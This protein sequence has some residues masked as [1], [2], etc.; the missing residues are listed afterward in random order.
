[1]N[2]RPEITSTIGV[3]TGKWYY[4]IY[5]GTVGAGGDSHFLGI[6]NRSANSNGTTIT[7]PTSNV[8]GTRPTIGISN[9][10]S[11]QLA[12]YD[13]DNFYDISGTSGWWADGSVVGFAFDINNNSVSVYKKWSSW[14]Y[15]YC[16]SLLL[17]QL[18]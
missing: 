16:K 13:Q 10:F 18:E 9:R 4:E 3:S 8:T 2:Q 15:F 12:F 17:S 14:I 11:T 1:L 7:I 5:T 6:C